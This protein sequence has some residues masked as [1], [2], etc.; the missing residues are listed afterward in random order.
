MD[1]SRPLRDRTK[2]AHKFGVG[3][4]LKTYFRKFFSPPLKNLAGEPQIYPQ[5]IEDCRQSEA[6]NFETSQHIDKQITDVFSAINALQNV[7]KLG[8]STPRGFD[9]T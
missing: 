6:L 1:L 2:F 4:R 3:S 9:A 8:A 5:I 7:T